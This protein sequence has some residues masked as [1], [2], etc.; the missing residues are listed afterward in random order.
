MNVPEMLYVAVLVCSDGEE[1]VVDQELFDDQ[2]GQQEFVNQAKY[3][4]GSTLMS[5]SPFINYSFACV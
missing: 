1:N 2:Q 4:M 5:Y 3:S